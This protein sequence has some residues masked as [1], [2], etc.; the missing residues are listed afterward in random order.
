MPVSKVKQNKGLGLKFDR[1][2][3]KYY[4]EDTSP[5]RK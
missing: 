3:R 1:K 2:A 4:I 5:A